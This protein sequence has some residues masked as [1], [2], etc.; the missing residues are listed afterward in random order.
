MRRTT[1]KNPPAGGADPR[2]SVK[3]VRC[4]V[5]TRKSSEE[6]LEQEFNS[7]DAQREA[8]EAFVRSQ[9]GEG[10][11]VLHERYDD[12]GYTGG[13][14]DRP[15]LQRL[16]A[17]VE[18]GRI[19]CVVVYKVDRLSRS[20]LDFARLMRTFE[21]RGA[22]FVSVTQQFNT[23]TS[24]GRLILNVL[25]SFAQ[26]EREIIGERTR[27]KIAA[28]RRKG[29]WA[30]GHPVLGYDIDPA[31]YKLVVN[32]AEAER[33]R[34]VFALYLEHGSL[35]PVVEELA[36]RGWHTKRWTTRKGRERGGK[37]FTRTS[38]YQML[39]SVAYA[40]KVRYKTEVHEGEHPAVVDPG[41]FQRVQENLRRNGR[42]G[43]EPV[44][45]QFGALLKG[46]LRCAPC[47]CAMTPT[48][49]T[50]G[51]GSRRYRYYVCSAAQK[52]GRSTCPSKSVP[53]GPVE[54]FVV[55]R[56]RAIGRDPEL[57]REV[58]AQ[59]RAT[60]EGRVAAMEAEASGLERDLRAWNAEVR[61]LSVQLRPGEDNGE[62]VGRLAELHERIGG[63]E[64]KV[65]RARA[66]IA[67]TASRLIPEEE[68]ARALTAFDPVWNSLTPRE[69]GRM[70]DLLVE[71]VDYD[72]AAG[73]VSVTFRP[74]GIRTLADE[75]ARE[76]AEQPKGKRA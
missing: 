13:N 67:G 72:G 65:R 16:M 15:G 28:T 1:T 63:V 46:L 12:G 59:A 68:A 27:D 42:T 10:W 23:A 21:E 75:L 38:L 74:A 49:T 51:G 53:A 52:K 61:R 26:F 71:R 41:I 20:L 34:K 3:L 29:K 70:I 47:G 37:P 36:R 69:Q 44:R 24:M 9:A 57:L 48:H 6:G 7:L 17:D 55:E 54:E 66:E 56:I 32:P 39:T 62:L 73:S 45:N 58:L 31:G 4:A 40:G 35:L 18:A 43:G 76:A 25:L 14:T 11:V 2:A 22:S 50:G 5:Y 60:D 64:A 30:G 19:D 33:V 8:G